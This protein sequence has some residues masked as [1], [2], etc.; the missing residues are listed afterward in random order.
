MVTPKD[1][2]PEEYIIGTGNQL[3]PGEVV[4]GEILGLSAAAEPLVSFP[5]I[6]GNK[7]VVAMSTLPINAEQVGRRVALLF[8]AG[9]LDQP[10]IIG[11]IHS[12]LQDLIDEFEATSTHSN[13]QHV[14]QSSQVA[15]TDTSIE[16]SIDGKKV[17]IEG[18]DEVVL[19]CGE[20]SITLK[21]SGKVIIRGKYLLNRS[22]GVNRILGGSVQI[23]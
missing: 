11:L 4:I 1:R 13:D 7:P 14:T 6:N 9:D 18:Q 16:A 19:K 23:N 21:K 15:E 10:L 2:K 5:Q 3:A 8:A 17:V 22:T 12:P 20:A